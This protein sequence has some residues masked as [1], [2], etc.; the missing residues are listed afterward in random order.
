MGLP[1]ADSFRD[2]M[3]EWREGRYRLGREY[4][5]KSR[6]GKFIMRLTYRG[7]R[8]SDLEAG[9]VVYSNA[10]YPEAVVRAYNEEVIASWSD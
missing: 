4:E 2:R 7:D 3:A 9:R 8:R 10:H 5:S 1:S 6:V